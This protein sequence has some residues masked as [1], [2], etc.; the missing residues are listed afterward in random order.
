MFIRI[1][2][3]DA[4]LVQTI[5]RDFERVIGQ[6]INLSKSSLFFSL[7]TPREQRQELDNIMGM[8][9]MV[10]LDKYLGLSLTMGKNKTNAFHFIVDRFSNHIK[11]WSKWL[12]S[13]GG[14]EVFSKPML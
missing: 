5:L 10:E 12:L 4:E 8:R 14:K 13:Y 6:K 2:K 11:G 9:I 7:N 3:G 1:K